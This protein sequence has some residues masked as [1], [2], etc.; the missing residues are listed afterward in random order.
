M[1]AYAFVVQSYKDLPPE[2]IIEAEFWIQMIVL[3][4]N[5]S[6]HSTASFGLN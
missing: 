5:L 4:G 1:T 6:L 2:H 3:W